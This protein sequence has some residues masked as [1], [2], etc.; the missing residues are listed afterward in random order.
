VGSVCEPD[1]GGADDA[2]NGNA[3]GTANCSSTH[4]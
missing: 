4:L 1:D 3:N 2:D